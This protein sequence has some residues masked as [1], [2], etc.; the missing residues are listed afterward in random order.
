MTDIAAILPVVTIIK[1]GMAYY[2]TQ[3]DGCSIQLGPLSRTP[4]G[5]I[6]SAQKRG[7]QINGFALCPS[8]A[9]SQPDSR[10][11]SCQSQTGSRARKTE[12]IRTQ[13]SAPS[14]P[15]DASGGC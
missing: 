13:T 4:E 5:A 15:A 7:W 10:S 1:G 8:C 2:A 11:C 14:A 3:C 6:V 12:S 9:V